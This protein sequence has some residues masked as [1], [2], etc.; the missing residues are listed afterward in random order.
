MSTAN[1]VFQADGHTSTTSGRRLLPSR[2]SLLFISGYQRARDNR[3]RI[4]VPFLITAGHK[5]KSIPNGSAPPQK[6]LKKFEK[7]LSDLG[8]FYALSSEGQY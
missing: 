4:I 5:A 3:A 6:K 2:F 1:R 8:G 7:S